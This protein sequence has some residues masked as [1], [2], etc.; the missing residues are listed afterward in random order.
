MHKPSDDP[1]LD[2]ETMYKELTPPRPV[3]SPEELRAILD[4]S[5]VGDAID[6]DHYKVGGIE[7][8][9]YMKAKST[10]EEFEGYLRLSSL[11]YLSRAGHKGEALEDYRKALWFVTRLVEE[12]E[13]E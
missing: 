3:L 8:I 7:T 5:T 10:P 6:P 2:P 13:R 11:K 4:E 1:F 12:G 9:D